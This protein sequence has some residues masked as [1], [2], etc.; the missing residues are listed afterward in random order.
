MHLTIFS[1]IA[2]VNPK[3]IRSAI[4][5]LRTTLL[6]SSKV[7]NSTLSIC[8]CPH[9]TTPNAC[10]AATTREA[11]LN[12]QLRRNVLVCPFQDI[13]QRTC[14]APILVMKKIE[15]A[16]PFLPAWLVWPILWTDDSTLFG[17]SKFTTMW[18]SST[19]RP[20][21]RH[22]WRREEMPGNSWTHELHNHT[23]HGSCHYAWPLR[24]SYPWPWQPHKCCVKVSNDMAGL[25]MI[26]LPRPRPSCAREWLNAQ[27]LLVQ[28]NSNA[29][30]AYGRKEVVAV[31]VQNL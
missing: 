13:G 22:Q 5:M 1:V 4:V 14:H 26:S 3:A 6:M 10:P 18:M 19:S 30:G 24:E 2:S 11:S 21:Q 7:E 16:S 17:K 29:K 23:P 20:W 8:G 27:W 9:H 31:V 28:H 15:I 12:L 25:V